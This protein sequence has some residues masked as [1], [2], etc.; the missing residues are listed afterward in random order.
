MTSPTIHSASRPHGRFGNLPALILLAIALCLVAG[1]VAVWLW[2]TTGDPAWIGQFFRSSG[3]LFLVGASALELWL[4]LQCWRQF[5]LGEP[6]GGA[7]LL[8]ALGAACHF[9]GSL[10]SELLGVRSRLNPLM[11]W[12][13]DLPPGLFDG[14]RA[15]G[16]TVGGP[17]RWLFLAGG[18]FLVLRVYFRSGLLGRLKQTDWLLAAAGTA[19]LVLE[20]A[21]VIAALRTGKVFSLRQQINWLNDPLVLVLLMEA[22]LIQRSL[23]ASGWG[24]VGRCWGSYM[25]AIALT[26]VGDLGIWAKAYGYA[27][28][29][30]EAV[31]WHI[32]FVAS[33]LFVLGPA[34][35]WEAARR[36][37]SSLRAVA[38][39]RGKLRSAQ[40]AQLDPTCPDM[41][42]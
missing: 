17:L 35:Q 4:C 26:C 34:Y 10:M 9:L 21:G 42:F 18:L 27:P 39:R 36:I 25:L 29:P 16:L 14:L 2:Q 13:A 28:W 32:W 22:I 7:W 41:S 33:A 15:L 1:V 37:R 40:Q 19:Y 24:L 23:L 3:A 38:L 8:L 6:L 20:A 5:S 30:A 11:L 12:P 31:G